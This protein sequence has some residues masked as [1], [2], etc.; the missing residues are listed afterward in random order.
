MEH[1]S[2]APMD[3]KHLGQFG[4]NTARAM[5]AEGNMRGRAVWRDTLGQLREIRRVRDRISARRGPEEGAAE[6]LLDN[7]Y[8]AQR[9]G[10]NGAEAFRRVRRI[11]YVL[12]G[13]RVPLI[14]ELARAFVRA[15]GKEAGPERLAIFLER[16]QEGQVLTEQELSLLI[17]ALKCALTERLATLCRELELSLIHI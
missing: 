12:R 9:E 2:F 13:G 7:W 3:D 17:P 8:L 15:A 11:R 6:W 10:R 16:A 4:E 14:M 1:T 5:R